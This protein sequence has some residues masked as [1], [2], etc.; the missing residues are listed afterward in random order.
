[1]KN[2]NKYFLPLLFALFVAV[3]MFIG[4]KFQVH[5][6]S[7]GYKKPVNKLT[8]VMRILEDSYVDSVQH[9]KLIESAI[10][11]MLKELDPHTTYIPAEELQQMSEALEGN[12]E[13]IGVEFNILRDTIVVV[14]PISGGPSEAL[15]IRAG[16]RIIKVEGEDVAGKKIRNEDVIK[17]LRGK[18]GTKVNVIIYRP[19]SGKETEYTI[20]RDRIPLH[21]VDATYMIDETTGFVKVNRFSG[22]TKREFTEALATLKK[23]GMKNLVLDLSG[24]PGGYLDA[25][26]AMADEFLEKGKLVVYTKGRKSPERKAFSS[27]GDNFEEG[28][29]VVLIDEGSASASEI[30]AGAIQDWDR[31]LVIGRRSFGKGLVQEQKVF[32]D[33][34]AMRITVSRYYTP[35]GRSIQRPY[36][37]GSEVYNNDILGR[38]EKGEFIHP[39]S[40]K[41]NDSLKYKTSMGRTVYGGGGIMPDV[42]V[43][44]DT[45]LDVQFLND[46]VSKGLLNSF[47]LD[48][49]D[50]NRTLIEKEYP[51]SDAY[52]KNFTITSQIMQDFLKKVKEA[53][54]KVDRSGLDHSKEYL[55]LHLKGLMGRQLFNNNVYF[56]ITNQIDPAYA[57]AV[58]IITGSQYNEHGLR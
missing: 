25:A 47:A 37:A 38:F 1:M 40:I 41:V 30:V 15:G 36:E 29:I 5:P 39:D 22:T 32:P 52:I 23:K 12:F 6:G 19:S 43:P 54:V 51:T 34:S 55:E 13:G 18:K 9:H 45:A 20:T 2:K 50:R 27:A 8:D 16:D 42:F 53:G 48:F 35:S 28:R 14:S 33:G 46:V 56:A 49:L 31:G 17:K 21:S 44:I 7:G 4:A 57:K 26:I 24:N 3:G 11:G 10:D 58:D